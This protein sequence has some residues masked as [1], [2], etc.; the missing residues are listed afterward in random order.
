MRNVR[1][2]LLYCP[3]CRAT[4]RFGR[5]GEKLRCLGDPAKRR[6]GCGKELAL[7]ACR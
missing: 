2:R 6:V 3:G 5:V 4:S 1:P 7:A